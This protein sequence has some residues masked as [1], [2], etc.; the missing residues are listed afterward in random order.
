MEYN[1][2][3][4]HLCQH[5]NQFVTF[6]RS[7][8]KANFRGL[9][10]EVLNPFLTTT[11]RKLFKESFSDFFKSFF[12]MTLYHHAKNQAISSLCSE[13]I[14]DFKIL[15][16]NVSRALWLTCHGLDLFQIWDRTI[17]NN[18]NI[19]C[20]TN[21]DKLKEYFYNMPFMRLLVRY[22]LVFFSERKIKE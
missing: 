17:A 8:N 16:S 18:I 15:Q 7:W 20:R 11:N 19:H 13:D 1:L 10:P 3:F 2:A 6:I 14:V 5:A 21:S 22:V 9:W 4:L 12:F